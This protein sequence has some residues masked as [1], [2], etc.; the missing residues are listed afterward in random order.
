MNNRDTLNRCWR[1]A[2]VYDQQRNAEVT[3]AAGRFADDNDDDASIVVYRDVNAIYMYIIISYIIFIIIIYVTVTAVY[4]DG[5]DIIRGPRRSAA[6][7]AMIGILLGK[8]GRY[9]YCCKSCYVAA[10]HLWRNATDRSTRE[11]RVVVLL[12]II[13]YTFVY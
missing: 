9:C 6:A 5:D 7:S 11:P 8:L 10:G 3:T 4:G 12:Y 2:S 13:L 1:S